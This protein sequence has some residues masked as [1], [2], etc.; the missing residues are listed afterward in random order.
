MHTCTYVRICVMPRCPSL[1]QSGGCNG[2]LV[3]FHCGLP[4]ASGP[5]QLKDRMDQK[6]IG[7]DKEKVWR[8]G[9]D[10][11]EEGRGG[12]RGGGEKDRGEERRTEGRGE[13]REGKRGGERGGDDEEGR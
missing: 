11:G 3:V 6:L 9:E 7:T 2:K 4:S 8:G 12:Q 13:E 5:G 1:P 10:R